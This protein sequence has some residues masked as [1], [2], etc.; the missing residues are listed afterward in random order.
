VES[1]EGAGQIGAALLEEVTEVEGERAHRQQEDDDEDVG[2]RGR[3]IAR[4][5]AAKR[6]RS[7]AFQKF[8]AP[9]PL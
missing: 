1:E 9:A 3:E 7:V 2:K 8:T 6:R 4:E 5:L